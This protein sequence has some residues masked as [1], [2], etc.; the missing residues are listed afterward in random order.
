MVARAAEITIKDNTIK[1]FTDG[2]A[3][4]NEGFIKV[5]F[6]TKIL[7]R[8]TVIDCSSSQNE[9]DLFT[10]SRYSSSFMNPA[11][12]VINVLR[13][14]VIFNL[15]VRNCS[16]STEGSGVHVKAAGSM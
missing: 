6:A 3:K 15:T 5:E 9:R 7:L 16:G 10:A 4:T 12:D 11:F 1:N 2:S 13:S 14:F 8:D